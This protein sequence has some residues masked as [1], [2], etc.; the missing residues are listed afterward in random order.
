M[1]IYGLLN[2][3]FGNLNWWPGD[4]PFEVIVGAI[5]TQNTAWRNVEIA[6]ANLRAAGMLSPKALVQVEDNTLAGLIRPSG[7]YNVKTQRL[8]AF[9]RFLH[10]EFGGS[11]ER[12]FAEE[13]AHLREILLKVKGIGEETADSILLYA[14]NKPVFVVDAYTQ[15]ILRRH[16]IVHEDMDYGQIQA[17]FMKQVPARISLYNQYHALL[18]NT[19]KSF[20]LKVP[21]CDDCPLRTLL[22]GEK[23]RRRRLAGR[24][25]KQPS[26]S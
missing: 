13:T 11:L 7:Y 25:G 6:I 12:M 14:G 4:T 20:C 24:K 3:Y 26:S 22:T 15:R 8:K 9:L 1:R 19:G 5:L 17:L 16:G 10:V 21:R 23:S 18:V 2:D